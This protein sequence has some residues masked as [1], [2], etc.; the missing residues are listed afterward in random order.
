MKRII[1]DTIIVLFCWCLLGALFLGLS[2]CA[3]IE[4]AGFDSYTIR[5]FKSDMGVT[6]CCE[7]EAK[8]GKEYKARQIS[9]E[10]NGTG[11]ALMVIEG[12]AKAFKGQALAVKALT[13]LPVNDLAS[14]LAPRDE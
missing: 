10:S 3:S 6:S 13:I 5:S 2:G 7:F 14:I 4:N 8:S 9:F 12:E 1:L 11:A